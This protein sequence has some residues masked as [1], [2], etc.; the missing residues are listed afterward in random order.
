[1]PD[2]NLL[3]NYPVNVLIEDVRAVLDEVLQLHDRVNSLLPETPLLGNLPELDSMAIITVI[4]A[5]EDKFNIVV[6]DDDDISAAFET[7]TSLM[8]YI[9]NKMQG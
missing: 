2:T 7:M 5:L 6:E 8:R 3:I 1:L 4:T 9:E